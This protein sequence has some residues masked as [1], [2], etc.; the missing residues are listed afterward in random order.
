MDNFHSFI[1]E[2][3]EALSNNEKTRNSVIIADFSLEKA[4]TTAEQ[5]KTNGGSIDLS[6]YRLEKVHVNVALKARHIDEETRNDL[7]EQK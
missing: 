2:E 3:I 1:E 4:K 5:W 7:M 6:M